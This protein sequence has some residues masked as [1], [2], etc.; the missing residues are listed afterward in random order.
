MSDL[1]YV[2]RL[3]SIWVPVSRYLGKTFG[4]ATKY[5]WA[6]GLL[7]AGQA[8]TMTGTYTGQFVMSGFLNLH[9]SVWAR[10]AITRS[11]ALVPTLAGAL[12]H[13]NTVLGPVKLIFWGGQ[14]LN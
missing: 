8:S 7:A 9:L 13:C 3:V 4:T 2:Q 5:I 12:P 1:Q 6:I 10:A 14:V 11:V